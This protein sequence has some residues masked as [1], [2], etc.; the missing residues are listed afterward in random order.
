[1]SDP[2]RCAEAD[3]LRYLLAHQNARDTLEGIEM[4]WL[5]RE[6]PYGRAEIEEAL[7][8]LEA[9]ELV[10]VWQS[11]SAQPIFGQGADREALQERLEGLEKRH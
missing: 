8:V 6:R 4:W 2:A 5:P 3:I 1:M 7:R 11:A 10:R 9:R